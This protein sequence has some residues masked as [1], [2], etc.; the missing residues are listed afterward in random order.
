MKLDVGVRLHPSF[1]Y[2]CDTDIFHNLSFE[3]SGALVG[4][5]CNTLLGDHRIILGWHIAEIQHED[6]PRLPH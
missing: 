6:R 2:E 1:S 3:L 5:L 4:P